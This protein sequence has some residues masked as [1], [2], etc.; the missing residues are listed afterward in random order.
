LKLNGAYLL[1][2][3]A[4]GANITGGSIHIIRKNKKVLVVASKEIGLEVNADT[5]KYMVMSQDKNAGRSHCINIDN[6]SFE[7][8][9]EFR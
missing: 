1:I 8:M 6:R 9:E 5:T 4:H 2:V 7:R 3:H